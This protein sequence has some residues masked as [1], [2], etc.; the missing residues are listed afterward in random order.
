MR[1]HGVL[2]P[3]NVIRESNCRTR[4]GDESGCGLVR[5]VDSTEKAA[6]KELFQRD[7]DDTVAEILAY[8][9]SQINRE[10]E[11]EGKSPSA[12]ILLIFTFFIPLRVDW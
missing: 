4:K 7:I 8:D 6:T 2:T 9:S 3:L 11:F 5:L 10:L 12:P 1:P